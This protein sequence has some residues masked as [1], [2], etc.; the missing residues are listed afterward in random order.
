MIFCYFFCTIIFLFK[1]TSPRKGTETHH[2]YKRNQVSQIVQFKNTSPRKG[3]ETH[4]NYLL[5]EYQHQ[6]RLKTHLPV[7]GRKLHFVIN[8]VS[9]SFL[10]FKNTSPRKGTETQVFIITNVNIGQN[11]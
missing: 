9:I 6:T 7:R 11:V 3:T 4:Q 8:Y 5:Y 2:K 1:N 10:K